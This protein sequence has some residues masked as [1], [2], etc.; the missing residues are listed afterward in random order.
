MKETGPSICSIC[1]RVYKN[2]NAVRS[3]MYNMHKRPDGEY[4]CSK[5]TFSCNSPHF[6][7]RHF[8]MKHSNPV[9]YNCTK[10][11]FFCFSDNGLNRHLRH[12]HSQVKLSNE[13]TGDPSSDESIDTDSEYDPS[14]EESLGTDSE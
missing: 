5:C 4:K 3:H 1:K 6:L 8:T 7:K 2:A 11:D 12:V 14:S 9:K 13:A 10:C